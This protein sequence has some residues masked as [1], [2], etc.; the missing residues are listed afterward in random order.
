MTPAFALPELVRKTSGPPAQI[1]GLGDLGRIAVGLKADI[2]VIDFDELALRASRVAAIC[3]Q[4]AV[5]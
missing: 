1:W 5:A 4:T 3:P 2:N